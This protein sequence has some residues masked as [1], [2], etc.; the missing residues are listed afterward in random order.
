MTTPALTV[1][2][3]P[4]VWRLVASRE[5]PEGG[6]QILLAPDDADAF[7]YLASV[8]GLHTLLRWADDTTPEETPR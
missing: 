2:D 5:H 3:T 7:T 6:T 4:G 1:R 8:S